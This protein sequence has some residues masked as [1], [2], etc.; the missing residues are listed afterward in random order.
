MNDP[1]YTVIL[2]LL[3]TAILIMLLFFTGKARIRRKL[4]KAPIKKIS[5]FKSGETAKIKGKVKIIGDP[6]IAPLSKR[7]CA[8]Y[9]VVVEKKVYNRR[10]INWK[11]IIN[12]EFSGTF[13]I[14]DGNEYAYIDRGN[15]KS[16]IMLDRNY[17]SGLSKDAH[18]VLEAYLN[19]HG[20][21]TK[22]VFGLNNTFRYKEG[23]L[24]NGESIAVLGKGKWKDAKEAGLPSDY[25]NILVISQE[26]GEYVYLS[27]DPDVVEDTMY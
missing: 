22:G 23:I 9:H 18:P 15:I 10:N 7:K 27:D 5:E 8:Y 21:D 20:Y 16:Y 12:K 4:G 26:K 17:T 3:G 19:S 25:K 24:E 6:V 2:L 13:V 14:K 1:V 11:T